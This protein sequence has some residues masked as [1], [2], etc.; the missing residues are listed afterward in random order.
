MEIMSLL[1]Q[2]QTNICTAPILGLFNR[3][4][5]SKMR[6]TRLPPTWAV[7]ATTISDKKTNRLSC[8]SHNASVHSRD[9]RSSINISPEN[10]ENE[11]TSS[12]TRLEY[13][14]CVTG[15]RTPHHPGMSYFLAEVESERNDN[16]RPGEMMVLP[17][18]STEA[19]SGGG[20]IDSCGGI[21]SSISSP[22]MGQPQL[23]HN[24]AGEG[25]G[26]VTGIG[27]GENITMSGDHFMSNITRY[28]I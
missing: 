19:I 28:C 21:H 20:G 10:N 24:R 14:N 13:V 26:D 5:V 25:S 11:T 6:N 7:V 22:T 18:P 27:T 23:E 12:S 17:A 16:K 3:H 8:I 2:R 15:E 9:D 1:Q 4:I